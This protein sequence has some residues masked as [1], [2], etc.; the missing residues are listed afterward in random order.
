[1]CE[2]VCF[3]KYAVTMGEKKKGRGTWVG[4]GKLTGRSGLIPP[5]GV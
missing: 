4:R 3:G 1:M 5:R 2:L